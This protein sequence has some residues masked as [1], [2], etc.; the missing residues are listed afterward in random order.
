[1]ATKKE[2]VEAQSFSRRRLLTAFVSGAPG[3]RELEPTSPVRGVVAGIVL[4]ALVVVGGL[5][6]G[7]LNRGL[8]KGWEN[9]QIIVVKDNAARYVSADGELVPV[10]N[11]ASA[12]LLVE[13]GATIMTVSEALVRDIERLG[14]AGITGAPDSLPAPEDFVQDAWRACLALDGTTSTAVRADDEATAAAGTTLSAPGIEGAEVSALVVVGERVHLVQGTRSYLIPEAAEIGVVRALG[15]TP[16]SYRPGL[17]EWLALFSP[18]E[19][20]APF[21]VEGTGDV[22]AGALGQIEG[23]AVGSVVVREGTNE[24]YVALADGRLARLDAF[25]AAVYATGTAG[26]QPVVTVPAADLATVVE[27]PL[28][29]SPVPATW[30]TSLVA[31]LPP[32]SGACAELD[33]EGFASV[34][35]AG[36]DIAESGTVSIKPGTGALALFGA[37]AGTSEGPVRFIDE[38]GFAYA[39]EGGPNG[40]RAEALERLFPESSGGSSQPVVVPYAWGDLFTSGPTLSVDAARDSRTEVPQDVADAE[41]EEGSS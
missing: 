6:S 8:P 14:R 1:M 20:V 41:G 2:L 35:V 34:L 7:L 3:G 4:A 17:E 23:V 27:V 29:E 25:S 18:S 19:D 16:E 10:T 38:N 33:A 40:D 12:R 30:P 28:A 9:G 15:F 37:T 11:M 39:I 5:A 13:P 26:Q 32:T 31:P 22:P 21:V 24:T 36:G